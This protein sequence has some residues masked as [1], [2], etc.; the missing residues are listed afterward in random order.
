M[1]E[2]VEVVDREH[3]DHVSDRQGLED[4]GVLAWVKVTRR[5]GAERLFRGGRCER[6]GGYAAHVIVHCFGEAGGVCPLHHDTR[7]GGAAMEAARNPQGVGDRDGHVAGGELPRGVERVGLGDGDHLAH[8]LG[9]LLRAKFAGCG[10]GGEVGINTGIR[11]RG[12]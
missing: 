8:G 9:A 12:E 1:R 4:D 10:H 5:G 6:L 11:R 2:G 7:A 3:G